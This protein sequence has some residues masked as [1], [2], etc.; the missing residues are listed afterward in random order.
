MK[1]RRK[2]MSEYGEDEKKVRWVSIMKIRR[3]KD[4]YNEDKKNGRW[5]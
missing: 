4:E 2:K 3:N 5:V 1:I